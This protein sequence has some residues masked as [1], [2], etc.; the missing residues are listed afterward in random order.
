MT[1]PTQNQSLPENHPA[2]HFAL[3]QVL[4][5]T[6]RF[7]INKRWSSKCGSFRGGIGAMVEWD[8]A[9]CWHRH[10][11]IT[12]RD[13]TR[14]VCVEFNVAGGQWKKD[15]WGATAQFRPATEA[16]IRAVYAEAGESEV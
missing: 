11:V 12:G 5:A 6:G 13:N 1:T 4:E 7:K 14:F 8:D 2:R 3:E 16:E 10:H 9:Y 15:W